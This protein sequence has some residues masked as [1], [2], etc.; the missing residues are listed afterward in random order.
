MN[1]A[2]TILHTIWVKHV[3]GFIL[4]YNKK[5]SESVLNNGIVTHHT[6]LHIAE[7]KGSWSNLEQ[8]D[9]EISLLSENTVVLY[10]VGEKQIGLTK[11][12]LDNS[13]ITEEGTLII[14]NI[15]RLTPLVRTVWNQLTI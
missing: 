1:K 11:G 3:D 7:F 14:D 13:V 12:M 2:A 4:C 6:R 8:L 5:D 15:L 10:I 9:K